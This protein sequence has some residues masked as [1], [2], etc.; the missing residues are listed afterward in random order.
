MPF[1]LKHEQA[2]WSE[3]HLTLAGLD[4]AGR[5]PLAGP[6]V[7]AAVH[8]DRPLL[9]AEAGGRFDGLRDSK[10]VTPA[11]RASFFSQLTSDPRVHIGVGRADVEEIDRLNILRATHLAMARA[12]AAL[13]TAVDL[14]LVD[15]L[16]VPGLPYPSRAIV[17]GDAQSLLI[18]AASIV[19]KVTRDRE[20][21]EL[22]RQYPR[23]GFAAHKGYGT[24]AHLA[25]LRAWGPTPQH[26]RS[27]APVAKLSPSPVP[28]NPTGSPSFL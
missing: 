10:Q 15:G 2:A 14:V 4:E 20:M 23:Y 13:K 1:L 3:G 24:A 9:E 21:E 25:A 22:D 12:L 28:P 19:A 11:R 26:R 18:A 8:I 17:Q 6:V 5:G 16:P 7:A 27:F